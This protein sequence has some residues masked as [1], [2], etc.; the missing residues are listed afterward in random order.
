MLYVL[1]AMHMLAYWLLASLR[2]RRA[3]LS[4]VRVRLWICMAVWAVWIVLGP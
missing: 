4:P 3:G 1:T 2:L